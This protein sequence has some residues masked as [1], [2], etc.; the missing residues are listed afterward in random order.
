MTPPLAMGELIV[1]ER[2]RR[3]WNTYHVSDDVALHAFDV[4]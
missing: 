4:I 2:T 1:R 3:K